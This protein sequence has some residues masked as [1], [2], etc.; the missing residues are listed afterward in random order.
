MPKLWK[1]RTI[2]YKVAKKELVPFR[3]KAYLSERVGGLSIP[4]RI[5]SSRFRTPVSEHAIANKFLL[6]LGQQQ[7]LN[8]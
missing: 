3:L 1:G 4:L 6:Q 7:Q 8:S 2:L 5:I